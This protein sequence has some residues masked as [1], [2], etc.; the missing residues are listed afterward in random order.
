MLQRWY[1]DLRSPNTD[2]LSSNVGLIWEN[3]RIGKP[4]ILESKEDDF[5][6]LKGFVWWREIKEKVRLSW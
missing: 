4:G 3:A 1:L 5:A 2:Q 6:I